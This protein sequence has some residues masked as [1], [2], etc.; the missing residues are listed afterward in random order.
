MLMWTGMAGYV[1]DAVDACQSHP[2]RLLVSEYAQLRDDGLS[3]DA[4]P[5]WVLASTANVHG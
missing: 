4:S 1:D 2:K 5:R 3:T